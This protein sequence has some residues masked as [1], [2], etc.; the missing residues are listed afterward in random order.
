MVC[1][2][3]K[4]AT[5]ARQV[6]IEKTNVSEPLMTCRKLFHRHRNRVGRLARDGAQRKPVYRL[7][8][9]RHKGGVSSIQ[10]LVWNVGTCRSDDKG[11][12]RVDGLHE[13]ASTDAEHRGGAARSSE[14]V[15]E[16]GWSEGA[17]LLGKANRPTRNGRSL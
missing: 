4:A 15:P 10:A 16:K 5:R 14:E 8:G 12:I 13:D 9:V 7:G 11:R 17:A 3:G 1:V 2:V 6:R